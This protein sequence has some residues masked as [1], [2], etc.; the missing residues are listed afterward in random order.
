MFLHPFQRAE[1]TL[2]IGTD[3]RRARHDAHVVHGGKLGQCL[4]SPLVARLARNLVALAQQGP[5]TSGMLVCQDDAGAAA[6]GRQCCHQAGRA[7]AHHQ[8]VAMGVGLFIAVRI[9]LVAQVP[10]TGGAPDDRLVNG[11]PE[12]LRPHEGLV[13]EAGDEQRRRDGVDRAEIPLQGRPAV[14]AFGNQP[15]IQ[16]LHGGPRIGLKAS[17]FADF[18]QGVGFGGTGGDHRARPVILERPAHQ[19][20]AVG[21]KRRRQRVPGMTLQGLAVKAEINHR[22]AVDQAA[23]VKTE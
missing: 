18:H 11:F 12:L 13:V 16:F 9:V 5:A 22:T 2:V 8:H 20:L 21:Q 14:L 3:N 19:Q 6:C 17:A 10:E 7:G 4:R 1:H 23:C 15:V